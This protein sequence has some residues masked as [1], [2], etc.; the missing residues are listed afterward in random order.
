MAKRLMIQGT[1]SG[2]GKSLFTAALC[3]IFHQEGV[4]VAPFKSQNMAL[5]SFVTPDGLEMGRAQAVQA[6]ACGLEPCVQMNPIL[7]KP[8]G[9]RTS[10]LV[11]MG[12]PVANYD[13][14]G[15]F[16]MKS[17]LWPVVLDAFADL[18]SRFDLICVEGAG[19]SAEINLKS[20][21]FVNMGLA[22]R[23]DIPVLLVGDI[24]RGGVFAQIAGTLALLEPHERAQVKAYVV[25]KFRGDI[26]ILRPGLEQLDRLTGC[27]AAGVVPWCSAD[28]DD[29]DSLSSRLCAR[30][31]EALLDIAVVKLPRISNFSDFSALSAVEG[32]GVRYV[33]RAHELG[34]PDLIILPGTKNTSADMEWMRACGIETSVKGAAARGVPL[35]GICG[36]YQM[37]GRE[38]I[39]EDGVESGKSVAGMGLL[40]ISTRF[41]PE[42]RRTRVRAR[43]LNPEGFFAPLSGAELE[44]YEIHCGVSER[45]A[46]PLL[47]L[48]DGS[49]DGCCQENVMGCYLHGFFD[50]AECRRALLNALASKKGVSLPNPD[51]DWKSYKESQY[52]ILA[53]TV[54][55]SLDMDLIRRI[56]D[57]EGV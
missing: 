38:I 4:R 51:F 6:E 43:V 30:T 13:A 8:T 55:Q 49:H 11:V 37:L 56:I 18:E 45:G 25:N 42:K 50:S 53:Q 32:V 57:G 22:R 39:D 15:Y 20:D 10:Q 24:E 52:D 33:E 9:D 34:S 41:Y 26:E 17:A 31:A 40:P 54:R 14:A 28:V 44:G 1:M 21:D 46:S 36:G 29:E 2:V 19:S 5:N 35:I 47:V 48:E 7:L 3:R 27:P 12:K 16:A 23:L